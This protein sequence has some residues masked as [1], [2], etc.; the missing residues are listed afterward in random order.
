MC[1]HKLDG[2]LAKLAIKEF[3]IPANDEKLQKD[4]ED[5]WKSE[6]DTLDEISDLSHPHIIQRIAAITRGRQRCLMFLWADGGNLR[7][8][9]IENPKPILTAA[10]IKNIIEQLRGMAEAL[11]KL[12]G[13]RD[14]YH[15]RHGDLKPENILNFPDP[16]K[17]RIGTFKISDLGSA[18]HHSVATRLRE[19]TGGKSFA[20]TVYQPPESITNK[21]SP[22]S[23]LY[24]IWSMG[25]V[26]LEFMVWV[27]YGY[28]ELK[29][30]T[31]GIKGKLEEPCSFFEVQETEQEGT[32]PRLVARLHPTVQAC[33]DRLSRDPE[34]TGKTALGD[35]LEVIKTK[36]LVIK[37]PEHTESSLVLD[38][39][40][41]TNTDNKFTKPQPF[42]PFGKH[43]TSAVGFVNALDDILNDE[44][45]K[46]ESYWFT[47]RSREN[48]P[49]IRIV[50][51]IVTEES[52][53]SSLLSPG[54]RRQP[55]SMADRTKTA[56]PPNP[57]ATLM[58]VPG[59]SQ[60]VR[61][62][63]ETRS[64]QITCSYHEQNNLWFKFFFGALMS[65]TSYHM[66]IPCSLGQIQ[67]VGATPDMT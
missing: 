50:P 16:D 48:L 42:Q 47:G 49:L 12:H 43:R 21:L 62:G 60:K 35:L 54:W 18:K 15:Y 44:N 46:K 8:F 22:S 52:S 59:P 23:R 5:V 57:P 3:I 19:R 38:N 20:T 61:T 6:V 32:T 40:S 13:Y 27:L 65:S 11:Q 28:E 51:E 31:T 26:T 4:A 36:L 66:L 67:D 25:C 1:V 29:K 56:A 41:V 53:P 45:A 17:S 9:W 55:S 14:Q 24:D 7:D 30:F 63:Q 64:S 34:C 2:S 39:V 37:L 58:V 33:L 10:L